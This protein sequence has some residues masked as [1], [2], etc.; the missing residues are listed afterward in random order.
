MC[1]LDRD[2]KK[3][4]KGGNKEVR[5]ERREAPYTQSCEEQKMVKADKDGMGL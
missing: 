3:A 5:F 2:K 4:F 1:L